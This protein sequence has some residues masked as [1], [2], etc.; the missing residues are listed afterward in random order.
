M[1][2]LDVQPTIDGAFVVFHDWTL[3][4]RADGHGVTRE[5]S[6]PELRRLDAGYGYTADG[7]K[8][9]PFRG[10]GVGLIPSLAD[11]L[12]AFP[13]RRLLINV[14]SNDPSEGT[15]LVRPS[16]SCRPPS[17]GS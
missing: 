3:D 17:G 16:A 13:H 7:G 12:S 6:M 15:R 9:F 8:T 1:V 11:V 14:K 5:H 10:K 4:C 2:E